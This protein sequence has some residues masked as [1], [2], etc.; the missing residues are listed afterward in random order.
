[1]FLFYQLNFSETLP[2]FRK[3]YVLQLYRL[4]R[5]PD[6]IALPASDIFESY[7]DSK[8]IDGREDC[9]SVGIGGRVD[10]YL[11]KK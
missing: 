7:L 2:K 3:Y 9:L 8:I 5:G 6:G 4:K 1:M 11:N 10:K